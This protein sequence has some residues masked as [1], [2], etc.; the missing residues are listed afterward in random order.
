MSYKK[1]VIIDFLGDSYCFSKKMKQ[2]NCSPADRKCIF[3][4]MLKLF[5]LC[6]RSFI[7]K[8]YPPIYIRKTILNKNALH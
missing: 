2:D 1:I 5:K 7:I 4:I 8:K 3:N 6:I